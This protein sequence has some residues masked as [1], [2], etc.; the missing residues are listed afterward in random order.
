MVIKIETLKKKSLKFIPRKRRNAH[1][2]LRSYVGL[3]SKAESRCTKDVNLATT[4]LEIPQWRLDMEEQTEDLEEAPILDWSSKMLEDMTERD[5]RIMAN[6]LEINTSSKLRPLRNW[7]ELP[8]DLHVAVDRAKYKFPTAIQSAVLPILLAGHD[9]VGTAQTGGGKTA[10]FV[11]PIIHK[12]D[13]TRTI[14]ALILA[15]TRELAQQITGEIFKLTEKSIAVCLVGGHDISKQEEAMS[16][17]PKIIVATPGRLIDCLEQGLLVLTS[18][19]MLVLDEADRLIDMGFEE[20]I[21]EIIGRMPSRGLRQ[22]MMFSA[23][24][25]AS[26]QRL[27]EQFLNSPERVAIGNTEPAVSVLQTFEFFTN[28]AAKNKRLVEVLKRAQLP[29]IV[30]VNT[31]AN[32]D[33]VGEHLN[34]SFGR[35]AI[36]HGGRTQSQRE[37]VLS[38]LRSGIV[39]VLVA[40]DVAGRGIDV[41]NLKTVVNYSMPRN[42]E[43]YT[44]RVGRTGRAGQKGFAVSFVQSID[45]HLFESLRAVIRRQNKPLPEW[46]RSSNIKEIL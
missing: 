38:D 33:A 28:T 13:A 29:A 1:E 45:E 44:H 39:K 2:V 15:P 40:T 21:K 23:T 18:C 7:T 37:A 17:K 36:M 42:F 30:F 3:G 4:P 26:I 16:V 41:P 19:Q 8:A 25:S 43:T 24:W 34:K 5:W 46:L 31:K 12:L 20:Q 32:A 10:G 11:L 22:T 35:V 6:D 27:A 14:Q 9:L